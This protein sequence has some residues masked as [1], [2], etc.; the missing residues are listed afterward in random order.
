M[1]D[2]IISLAQQKMFSPR[3]NSWTC[4]YV[5]LYGKMDFSDVTEN[6]EIELL[7]GLTWG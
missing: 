3:P 6:L 7:H 4:E 2:R 1:A 5:I